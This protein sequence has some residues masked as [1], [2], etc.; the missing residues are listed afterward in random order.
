MKF[1][2]VS[3]LEKKYSKYVT[4]F[5]EDK[6][7]ICECLSQEN[8]EFVKKIIEKENFTGK[9]DEVLSFSIFE[10]KEILDLIYLGAGKEDEFCKSEYRKTLYKG[11][12]NLKGEVLISSDEEKLSNGELL[13]EVTFHINYRFEKYKEKKDDKYLELDFFSEK[14]LDLNEIYWLSEAT[15]LAKDLVNEQ[16]EIMT[17]EKLSQIAMEKGVEAGLEVE[18][19][20]EIKAK[21]LGMEAFLAVGRASV[22]RP[23]L[24]IMR[25]MGDSTSDYVHG[26]VGKGLTYDT[27]GLSLKPTDSMINMKDDMGGSAAVIGAMIAIGQNKLKKNV[28]AVVAACENSIGSKA[29]RPGD[30]VGTMAGKYIEVINTDA[31]GRLTLVDAMTYIIRKEKVSEVVD[32]ATLTGAIVVALGTAATGVFTNRDEMYTKISKASENWEEKYWHMPIFSEHRKAIKSDIACVKNSA[33]RWG[34]SSTAAAFLEEFCENTPWMHLDIAGTALLESN[35]DYDK[36]GA[37]GVGVK[38]LY[39]YIKG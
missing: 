31:E 23:H 27:G 4:V 12:S 8:K 20:D 13:A 6:I 32:V 37:T 16:A 22:N 1:N 36:K 14:E 38:T 35:G 21:E 11:L 15:N 10:N 30:I 17:P 34:G 33:G 24:I 28:V 5:F 29:Y 39:N 2:K 18:I 9:K 26:L 3:S 19:L 7:E 25:H